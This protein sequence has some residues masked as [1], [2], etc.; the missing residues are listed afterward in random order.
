MF[1]F[2]GAAEDRRGPNSHCEPLA[3][4]DATGEGKRGV[5]PEVQRIIID[6][7]HHLEEV[8]LEKL[9][10]R[11]SRR[12]LMRL[13]GKAGDFPEE[14][15]ALTNKIEAA[16]CGVEGISCAAQARSCLLEERR[17]GTFYGACRNA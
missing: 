1:F 14:R 3:A 8:A 5:L 6:E 4:P 13:L 2:Q 11:Y 15:V 9:S 17:E 12:S 10:K 16:F 7:A